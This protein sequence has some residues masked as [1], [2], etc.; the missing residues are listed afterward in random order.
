MNQ[1]NKKLKRKMAKQQTHMG[2]SSSMSFPKGSPSKSPQKAG[3]LK[4]PDKIEGL[5]IT[6]V[7]ISTQ[8]LM[9]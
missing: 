5:N 7:G 1:M 3:E 9:K 4:F 6:P 2:I 8:E